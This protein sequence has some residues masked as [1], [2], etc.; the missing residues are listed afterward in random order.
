MKGYLRLSHFG[1]LQN[2]DT[3]FKIGSGMSTSILTGVVLFKLFGSGGGDQ[4][5]LDRLFNVQ[6]TSNTF[7]NLILSMTVSNRSFYFLFTCHTEAQGCPQAPEVNRIG[8]KSHVL[9]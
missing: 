2:V 3:S 8:C 5:H 9:A 4:S 7:F 6:S 1:L